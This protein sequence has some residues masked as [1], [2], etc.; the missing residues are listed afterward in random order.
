MTDLYDAGRE[1]DE[2]QARARLEEL[3]RVEDGKGIAAEF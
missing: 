2:Q 1:S 3:T